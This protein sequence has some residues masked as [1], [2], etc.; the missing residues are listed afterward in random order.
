MTNLGSNGAVLD[1]TGAP[2]SIPKKSSQALGE[3][4]ND[5][6][7]SSSPEIKPPG[8][9]NRLTW[10]RTGGGLQTSKTSH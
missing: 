5:L 3:H 9:N 6:K 2:I 4:E 1:M 10:N 7:G 8:L